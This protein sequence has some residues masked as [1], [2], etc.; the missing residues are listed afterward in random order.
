MRLEPIRETERIDKVYIDLYSLLLLSRVGERYYLLI[1]DDY[2]RYCQI[3]TLKS[4]EALEVYRCY[5]DF[6]RRIEQQ[7]NKKPKRVRANSRTEFIDII[8]RVSYEAGLD[9]TILAPY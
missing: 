4:K 9:F 2:T 3:Y 5:K 8:C 1:V 6:E 7:F